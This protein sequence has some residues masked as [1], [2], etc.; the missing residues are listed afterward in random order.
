[1]NREDSE[2]LTGLP[3][4]GRYPVF[5]MHA[6]LISCHLPL[7]VPRRWGSV[8]WRKQ[9][10]GWQFVRT[11]ASHRRS[12]RLDRRGNQGH[13]C[14]SKKCRAA[15]RRSI[16]PTEDVRCHQPG[17]ALCHCR[18]MLLHGQAQCNLLHQCSADAKVGPPQSS[19]RGRRGK[20]RRALLRDDVSMLHR[21]RMAGIDEGRIGSEAMQ[22]KER[23]HT[24]TPS[25]Q[26]IRTKM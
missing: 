25:P 5:P 17:T 22:N 20:L 13:R 23:E 3:R 1:M 21:G 7:R 8:V 4:H 14:L 19:G 11:A 16:Q 9:R 10:Q 2:W 12:Q 15:A 26:P 18:R 24:R 6:A